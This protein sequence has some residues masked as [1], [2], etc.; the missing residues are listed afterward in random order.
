MYYSQFYILATPKVFGKTV[1]CWAS[2][3][4][5][6]RKPSTR[7]NHFRAVFDHAALLIDHIAGFAGKSAA[8]CIVLAAKLDELRGFGG[9]IGSI[10]PLL[11]LSL[12]TIIQRTP[13]K[14]LA[15]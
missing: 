6:N 4:V 15:P 5:A 7:L 9:S 8:Y 11:P 12:A 1:R 2:S 3:Q 14:S 13:T 10:G